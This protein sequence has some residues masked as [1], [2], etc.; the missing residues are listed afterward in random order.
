MPRRVSSRCRLRRERPV[1]VVHAGNRV[2]ADG[3]EAPGRFPPDQVD[4]VRARLARLL[5]HVR[6]EVVVSA[7]AAGSDLLVL[8]EALRLGL[9]VHVVLPSPRNVFRERSVADRGPSWTAAYDQVLAAVTAGG[10][11]CAPVEH[12]LPDTDEGYPQ[13]NQAPLDHARGLDG[14]G[15]T[16]AVAVRPRARRGPPSMTDDF[17]DRARNERLAWIDLDPGVRP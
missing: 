5:A 2:D 4:V 16:L 12:A 15:E 10:D 9:A 1:L 6:P 7:A 8:Q 14:R 17:V 11:A 13:G 3:A